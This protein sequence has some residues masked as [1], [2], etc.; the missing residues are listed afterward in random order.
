MVSHVSGC[1]LVPVK[2]ER[3]CLQWKLYAFLPVKAQAFIDS[4]LPD[5]L[6]LRFQFLRDIGNKRRD[7]VR[8]PFFFM[9]VKEAAVITS[10]LPSAL[11]R[12]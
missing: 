5:R 9:S 11:C 6:D 10:R 12:Q 2:T 1:P 7:S 4:G 8:N 3:P